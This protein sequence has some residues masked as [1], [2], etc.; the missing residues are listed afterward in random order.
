MVSVLKKVWFSV[1]ITSELKEKLE[2]KSN[3]TG[4]SMSAIAIIAMNKYFAEG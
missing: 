4:L 2:A 3:E 1:K